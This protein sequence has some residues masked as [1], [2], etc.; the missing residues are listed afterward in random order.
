MAICRQVT[1]TPNGSGMPPITPTQ[2]VTTINLL[3]PHTRQSAQVSTYSW[4]NAN[5]LR[6]IIN[7][8]RE[9]PP[10]LI[11]VQEHVYTDMVLAVSAIQNQLDIWMYRGDIGLLGSVKDKTR[12]VWSCKP[13]PDEYPPPPTTSE[14]IFIT[15]TVLRDS[16]R[17]DLGAAE[18]AFANFEWKAATILAGAAI[19]ALLHWRL[20]QPPPT[21]TEIDNSVN[22]LVATG[23]LRTKPPLNRDN[24]SLRHFIEVSG[25]LTII[26]ANTVA[27]ANLVRDFRNLIHPGR[28]ARTGQSCNRGTAA[29]SAVAALD[30]VVRDLK[31]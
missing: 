29:R 18:R 5:A 22:A 7:L 13:S 23:V 3:F 21:S 28:A 16:I 15:D 20:D 2:A 30:H 17:G 24:W 11:V 9:I 8:V 6:G 12:F 25:Y 31:P 4:G 26:R 1:S 19:E 10:E 14:L 27:A